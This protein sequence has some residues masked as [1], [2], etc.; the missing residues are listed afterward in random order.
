[1]KYLIIKQGDRQGKATHL[2]EA[3]SKLHKTY[4]KQYNKNRVDTEQFI[5]DVWYVGC[6]SEIYINMWK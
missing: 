6:L 4:K 3:Q 2:P 5:L 1:M